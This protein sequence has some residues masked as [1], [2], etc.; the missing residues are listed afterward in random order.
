[1]VQF[2][3]TTGTLW[4]ALLSMSRTDTKFS[5]STAVSIYEDDVPEMKGG[6]WYHCYG[7]WWV[8]G[9]WE[10]EVGHKAHNAGSLPDACC[11]H[12]TAFDPFHTPLMCPERLVRVYSFPAPSGSP[13]A[14][15]LFR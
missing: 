9:G 8:S 1:M 15:R 10:M 6:K 2:Q 13:F 3:L 11:N 7:G 14:S 4:V 12:V 5:V